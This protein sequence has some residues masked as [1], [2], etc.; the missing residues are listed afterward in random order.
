MVT[1]L[2]VFAKERAVAANA[3]EKA[4]LMAEQLAKEKLANSIRE[5]KRKAREEKNRILKEERAKQ[6]TEECKRLREQKNN[7]PDRFTHTSTF[8]SAHFTHD[9]QDSGQT[10]ATQ[11][12]ARRDG[13]DER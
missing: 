8:N 2:F 3:A 7:T 6:W 4:E 12:R 1:H 13:G 11:Q 9:Q 5:E 10:R